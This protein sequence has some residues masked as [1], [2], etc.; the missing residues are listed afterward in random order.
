MHLIKVEQHAHFAEIFSC[1]N[2]NNDNVRDIP[3]L[4]NQ[5]NIYPDQYGIL[6]VKSKFSRW[7]DDVSFRF[8]V[9]LPKTSLLTKLI[10]IDFHERLSH[11]G[12][13]RL[14]SELRK[15]FWV[16]HYFSV[17]K[18]V[19]KDCVTCKKLKQRTIKLNQSS[20]REFRLD[21]PNIPFRSIFID[22]FGPYY[23]MY[24]SRK[25]KIWILCLTCL[26]SRAIN[27]K[28]C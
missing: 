1:F 18:K 25:V 11:A 13:Y 21:P 4:V 12:C 2:S 23:I 5:L 8:P 26:W 22:N 24:G 17:V 28:I 20:Y 6:R 7:S 3:N 15:I 16:T 14:L 10:I 19:I 27:L 9:L